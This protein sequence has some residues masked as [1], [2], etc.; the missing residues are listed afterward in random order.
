[1]GVQVRHGLD[2]ARV[3]SSLG[4]TTS[5]SDRSAIASKPKHSGVSS[6]PGHSGVTSKPNHPVITSKSNP[7]NIH[8]PSNAHP[9]EDEGDNASLMME[10]DPN[11][12]SF[13]EMS[14]D[15]DALEETMKMY[16]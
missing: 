9:D 6:E 7:S 8:A 12:S 13:G 5:R 11:D 15:M 14:F 2:D 16:D 1:M 3:G 10:D 4:I